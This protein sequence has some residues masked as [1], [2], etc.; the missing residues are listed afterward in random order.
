MI[1]VDVNVIEDTLEKRKGWKQSLAVLTLARQGRVAGA[2]SALTVPILYFLQHKPDDI[3]R[4]NVQVA[5]KTLVI[6]DLTATIIAAA[7]AEQ[8]TNDFEDAIQFYS[9]KE[10]GADIIVTRNKRHFR[11]FEKEIQVQSPEEF[12]KEW[13]RNRSASVGAR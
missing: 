4:V 8:R 13:R 7:F 5:I 10:A 3:A 11:G 1:L 2:I 6:V 12:L 9:A